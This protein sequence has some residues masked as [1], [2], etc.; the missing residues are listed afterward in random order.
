VDLQLL[1]QS[2]QHIIEEQ[3]ATIAAQAKTIAEQAKTIAEQA[4]TIARLEVKSLKA[5]VAMFRNWK[6]SN[7]CHTPPS[8]DENRPKKFR[9]PCLS[10]FKMPGYTAINSH[11]NL[12]NKPWL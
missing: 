12:I 5:E 1:F 11:F 3:G 6:N 7:N 4:K 9:T 8:K 10:Q 2:L